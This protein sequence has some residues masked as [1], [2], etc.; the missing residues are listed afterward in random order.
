MMVVASTWRACTASRASSSTWIGAR[1]WDLRAR[2]VSGE[3]GG[4]ARAPR[5]RMSH[6]LT[7]AS[8]DPVRATRPCQR[9]EAGYDTRADAPLASTLAS[10]LNSTACTLPMWPASR[11]VVT[12]VATSQTKTDLSPPEEANLALS[13]LLD[14][15]SRRRR[16]GLGVRNSHGYGEDLV[17]VRL[18]GLDLGARVGV[19]EAHGAVLAT[20]QDVLGTPFGIA[21][22]VHRAAMAT[23]RRV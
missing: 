14:G 2:V 20:T 22:D 15:V 13:W 5:Y 12:A 18:K 23:K 19:P 17:S 16:C 7:V 8:Y 4:G 6:N 3:R 1:D 11:R 9:E 21:N 10:A